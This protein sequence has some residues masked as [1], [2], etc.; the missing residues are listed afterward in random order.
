MSQK[1]QMEPTG[2]I[3]DIQGFSVHDGPGIRTTVF[4]K[5]CPLRCPWCHSPE[6]QSFKT[7]LSFMDMR[8]VGIAKCGLCLPACPHGALT[9]GETTYSEI[10]KEDIRHVRWNGKKCKDCGD[11]AEACA[12]QALFMC[13]K[14][15]TVEEVMLRLRKDA[16]YFSK[17][18][19]G[20]TVSGGEAMSQAAFTAALLKAAHDEGFHTALDTTGFADYS[21]FAAA[22]PDIDLFL[23]DIKHMDS[24]IHKKG[25]GVPNEKI[26]EN[27]RKLAANGGKFQIRVPVIPMYNDSEGNLAAVANFCRDIKDAVEL[28]QLLPFH[29]FGATK[30]DRIGQ[31][32]SMP[33]EIL[34]PSPER[35]E[36]IADMMR[37]YGLNVVI[38]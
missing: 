26:L 16:P 11:C 1:E 9:E 32:Y 27:A 14:D 30:Y 13:G 31:K 10:H 34:P 35:M 12:A 24:E 22:L 5:G 17:S 29:A 15:Y 36:E 38:H 37:G 28:V 19:G 3:Y 7:Q 6:S 21:L 4:L 33:K 2:K 20:L 18:G 8:C 23:Y 25:V